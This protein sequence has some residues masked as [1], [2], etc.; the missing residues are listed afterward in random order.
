MGDLCGT[1]CMV[2]DVCVCVCWMCMN[3]GSAALSAS[4]RVNPQSSGGVPNEINCSE[5][6][7]LLETQTHQLQPTS[8]PTPALP[9]IPDVP[10]F[11][12]HLPTPNSSSLSSPSACCFRERRQRELSKH[13]QNAQTYVFHSPSSEWSFE[14]VNWAR[15]Y[16][17]GQA[18]L[19]VTTRPTGICAHVHLHI[20]P[21][22]I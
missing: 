21:R 18:F 20:K 8:L 16:E 10:P 14:Y 12:P 19:H 11:S 1:K 22:T 9:L 4:P 15:K 5:I 17:G 6:P 13:M 3:Q 7:L 2:G